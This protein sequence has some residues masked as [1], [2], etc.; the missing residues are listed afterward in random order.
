MKKMI[1][2]FSPF[3]FDYEKQ[4]KDELERKG[5]FVKLYSDVSRD[6]LTIKEKFLYKICRKKEK[7][8]KEKEDRYFK[9]ILENQKNQTYDFM[10]V[11]KG[12]G[13]PEWFYKELKKIKIAKKWISYQWDDI[14]NCSEVLER[15]KYFHKNYSYSQKDSTKYQYLYR[16]FFFINDLNI[17]KTSDIFFVGTGHSD[18]EIVLKRIFKKIKETFGKDG[19]KINI[20]LLI[21][22]SKYIKKFKWLS[23]DKIY[24]TKKMEYKDV[25]L[26]M[27]KNRVVIEIPHDRQ[28][29]TTTRA[30]EAIGTRTKIITTV[31]DVRN[32]DF[33]NENNYLIIDRKNPIISKEWLEKS[34]IQLEES[35]QNYYSL[36]SWIDEIFNWGG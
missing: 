33:Y 34:Y 20:N 18:R 4:I 24:I 35:I 29:T 30:I 16:P 17:E 5:Y 22:R 9:N 21:K 12:Q 8:L 14:G 7:V 31:E 2:M 26:E 27:A 1:L 6:K 13:I 23:K 19:L 10:F 15:K 28:F 32:K 36:S 11:I 3:F 25:I